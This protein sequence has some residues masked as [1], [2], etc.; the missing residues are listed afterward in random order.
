MKSKKKRRRKSAEE[1]R[2]YKTYHLTFS[3]KVLYYTEGFLI[4][5][6]VGF[7]FYRSLIAMLVL[8]PFTIIFVKNKR[9]ELAKKQRMQLNLEFKES[10]QAVS[11]ALGAGYS[12]ENSFREALKDMELLYG[13]EGIITKEIRRMVGK[14]DI[15]ITLEKTLED[16]SKRS[17]LEDIQDFTEVF[18]TAK[19]NGGNLVGI[20]RKAAGTIS[21]KIEV[22]RE[23]ET[24]MSAR[25]MEQ[26][27]MNMIP[28]LIIL[29]I[30]VSSKGFLDVLYGNA[31][32]ITI[33]SVCLFLY[34]VA[35]FLSMKI[36]KI[37]V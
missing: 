9:E 28:F 31:T 33:M 27:I 13:V 10:I 18:V 34:S 22:K 3:E 12:I 29:Y 7:T 14:L 11:A 16:L 17:G 15:N 8:S 5:G 25:R 24:L 19:R 35:F 30:G 1:E 37:E 6:M 4:A 32:G 20:I 21:E 23:I 26:K 2:D 36:I